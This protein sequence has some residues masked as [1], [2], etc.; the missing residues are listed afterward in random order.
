MA[1]TKAK[2]AGA[3][4][5]DV[6]HP[7]DSAPST[8]SKSVIIK[9]QPMMRDPMM[10]PLSEKAVTDIPDATTEPAIVRYERVV[11]PKPAEPEPVALEPAEAVVD[12]PGNFTV[13]ESIPEEAKP[14]SSS[15]KSPQVAEID[16]EAE[17]ATRRQALDDLV[18]KQTFFLPINSSSQQKKKQFIFAIIVLIVLLGA[19]WFE[20]A[21][22]AGLIQI[23]GVKAP[24]DFFS[25]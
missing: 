17:T 24:T 18:T 13:S 20:V 19:V 16:A 15:E 23:E 6:A 11:M 7:N 3:R 22:D 4:I 9:H 12:Q 2:T 14:N 10:A 21:L 8:T 1:K 5:I 25:N